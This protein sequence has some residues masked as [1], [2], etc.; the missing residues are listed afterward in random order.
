MRRCESQIEG[1]ARRSS[2][3]IST[4]SRE[5]KRK[6]GLLA[7]AA[8]ALALL[9]FVRSTAPWST[10][11]LLLLASCTVFYE[12]TGHWVRDRLL[13]WA[14]LGSLVLRSVLSLGF[15][16]VSLWNIPL[17]ESLQLGGGFWSFAPDGAH[18]HALSIKIVEAWRDGIEL[19]E[20]LGR[21][22]YFLVLATVYKLVGI[23][24]LHGVLLNV[25]T[26]TASGLVAYLAA[27]QLGGVGAGR[28]AAVL[29]AFWPS[30]VLWS[31]QLLKEQLTVFLVVLAIY[32]VVKICCESTTLKRPKDAWISHLLLLAGAFTSTF[33]IAIG[34]P[35]YSKALVY[36]ALVTLFPRGVL[37]LCRKQVYTG[38]G[39]ICVAICMLIASFLGQSV[40]L[41]YLF[42][43][44]SVTA[45]TARPLLNVQPTEK[46]V[47]PTE[48]AVQWVRKTAA[49]FVTDLRDLPKT[50]SSLREGQLSAAGHTRIYPEASLSSFG[51]IFFYLPRGLAHFFL[52]PFPWQSFDSQGASGILISF[53]RV[54]MF[55][56]YF[57]IPF[58][59]VGSWRVHR[60]GN[61]A[62]LFLLVYFFIGAVVLSLTIVNVG[63]LFRYR[64][65]LFLAP[66]V[67]VSCGIPAACLR[68]VKIWLD[69]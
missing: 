25:V 32:F 67:C 36:S 20:G 31:T 41:P 10:S 4:G 2:R 46:A 47:Q 66:L 49:N 18:H 68:R 43:F 28:V 17:L 16:F 3:L 50:V 48:K 23:H 39:L 44:S 21:G 7:V 15:Y 33:L 42:S 6:W 22:W 57:L 64:V 14:V 38:G 62:S 19:P 61:A 55:L 5:A 45:V 56:I 26:G 11:A 12:I 30:I 35:L 52:A 34:R 1:L 27:T 51:K 8:L 37:A 24:P 9:P 40:E 69:S 58:G 59:L 65:P 60:S 53:A 13:M 29:V 54:E 63:N